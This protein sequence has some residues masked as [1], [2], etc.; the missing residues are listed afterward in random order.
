M[1]DIASIG[2]TALNAAQAGL[3]TTEHNIANASTPGY[4][5]QQIVQQASMPVGSGT[6]FL[7]Q[8][9]DVVTV[10][11]AYN[12]F[13]N[14]QL[15]QQ[16]AQASQLSTYYT[17]IQQIN[18]V[19]ADPT[20]GLSAS[21]Q[22][23]FS[24]VNGVANA[25]DSAAARQTLLSSGQALSNTFQSLNQVMTNLGTSVNGQ[26]SSSV[27]NINSYAQQIAS[28]N[29]NIALASAA[30]SGQQP[31][32]LLDQRD[33]LV[34]QLNQEVKATVIKQSDGSYNVFIGNGQ[35]LVV[36]NQAFTLQAIPSLTDS[37][38]L[39]VAYVANGTTVRMPPGS[40]QGGNLGGLL[41]FRDQTLAQSQN[42]LGRIAIGL[43]TTFNAQQSLGQDLYGSLGT[44][45]FNVATPVVGT[46]SNNTGTG[47]VTASITNVSALT[48]SDYSLS[49]D[50]TNYTLTRLSD[51]K[52]T[53]TAAAATPPTTLS[54]DGLSI[55]ISGAPKAGDNFLIR[56]TL[57]G[58]QNI[59]V[60]I[61]DPSQ[62]AAAVPVRAT[63][64]LTNIGSGTIA[65]PTVNTPPPPDP[66]LQ[67]QVTLAFTDPTHYNVSG[68]LSAT[69]AKAN[70][71]SGVVTASVPSG[72]G[73]AGNNYTISYDGTNYTLTESSSGA[74]SQT[75]PTLPLTS[76]DGVTFNITGTPKAGDSFTLASP[77]GLTYTT[78]AN[79]S[80]NGWTSSIT[81]VPNTNDSFTVSSNT[82]ATTD[83]NNALLLANL[84][85]RN[86]LVNG[87]VS[88]AGAYAQLVGQIGAQTN[89]LQ[90]TSQA[91]S[92]LVSQTQQT[93]QSL[94]GVNL[95]EEAANLIKYQQAY[96]AA[97]KAIQ[98]A[99][100]LFST[101]LNLLN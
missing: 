80:Y 91:Q 65:T 48:G 73:T 51:N 8:G 82:N 34:S 11:R 95:D 19:I 17:Q 94:S 29:Q 31:N 39:D 23:F 77:V 61:S 92:N 13:I 37:T 101:V 40:L 16:Q 1:P 41:A 2:V 28:L 71:G 86:T 35:S 27:G 22:S 59:G 52:V 36:G 56:P 5:K 24:A 63:A 64:S 20:A 93:Q 18:N 57:N 75:S 83:G 100:T 49:Y 50:G 96:Q 85:S 44:A 3:F 7:G 58:A 54:V 84:Q 53:T 68:T 14:T 62:I 67:Q 97:G 60:A 72:K 99:D 30:N 45:F 78:G 38:K 42:A 79:I 46:N 26:I 6:G 25:P 33:Q 12:D 90:V 47:S 87:T 10:K 66:N 43:G 88:Y 69:A 9:V 76:S 89:Q 98:T 4:N 81:G 32:D 55:S 15:L 70:T 21:L 74:P